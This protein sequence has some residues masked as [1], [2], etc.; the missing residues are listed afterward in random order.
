MQMSH[1]QML[2]T[3]YAHVNKFSRLQPYDTVLTSQDLNQA[4]HGKRSSSES[5]VIYDCGSPSRRSH[6]TANAV[7]M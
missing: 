6:D 5:L 3:A 1:P 7:T 2:H 4:L